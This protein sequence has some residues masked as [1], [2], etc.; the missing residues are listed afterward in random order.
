MAGTIWIKPA[1]GLKVRKP[2]DRLRGF[3]PDEGM[4]VAD[5]DIHWARMIGWGDVIV[6]DPPAA[7]TEAG[8][9][10]ATP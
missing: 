2:G 10:G 8:H 6:V 1:P 7:P 9:E 3:V 5:D 4:P